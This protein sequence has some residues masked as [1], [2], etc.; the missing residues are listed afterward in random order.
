MSSEMDSSEIEFDEDEHQ[1]FDPVSF[2]SIF[3]KKNN[4]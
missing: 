2:L 4:L 3:H 1:D